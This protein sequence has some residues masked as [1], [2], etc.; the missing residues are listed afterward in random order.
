MTLTSILHGALLRGTIAELG[1]TLVAAAE[2]VL[3][4]AGHRRWRDLSFLAPGDRARLLAA[5]TS[6]GLRR[7]TSI[8]ARRV[9]RID[10]VAR[11]VPDRVAIEMRRDRSGR[12]R[13]AGSPVS[14]RAL[15]RRAAAIAA[16]LRRAA[17]P[18]G[19]AGR[20]RPRSRGRLPAACLAAGSRACRAAARSAASARQ[21]RSHPGGFRRR[22]DADLASRTSRAVPRERAAARRFRAPHPDALAYVLYTSGSTGRP[23]G[24]Q[25]SHGGARQLPRRDRG[26]LPLSAGEELLA[27]TTFMF[28]ISFLEVLLPLVRGATTVLLEHDSTVDPR[29]AG[30][31]DR[32]GADAARAGHAVALAHA[33]GQRLARRATTS[34]IAC[35]GERLDTDLSA[36]LVERSRRAV[37]PLRTDGN[38]D[39]VEQLP[40]RRC[41]VPVRASRSERRWPTIASTCWTSGSSRCVPAP[42]VSCYIGG[43]ALAR[44]YRGRAALTAE[45]FMPDPWSASPGA[46]MY[47]TGDLVASLA[48]GRHS[49][50]PAQ[51]RSG[52]GSR[53]SHRA[54]RDRTGGAAACRRR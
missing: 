4:A 9:E 10:A 31:G 46:R 28:D 5:G 6:R 34:S 33:R 8:D 19:I 25:I 48:R 7:R 26:Q 35:G 24:V 49:L 13:A 2:C 23:K 27:V 53:P 45:R 18:A 20:R 39:L 36:A 52:Q 51:G 16:A 11:A 42:P 40:R 14:Y 15:R 22:R 21:A 30:G 29:T 38:H 37:E 3:R 43:D 32:R 1:R 50:P 54:G 41:P 17:P 44:G 47:R 12:A